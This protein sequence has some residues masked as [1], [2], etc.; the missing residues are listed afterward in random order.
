MWHL[1]TRLGTFWVVEKPTTDSKQH[2]YCLGIDDE[3]LGEY[4]DADKA[5]SD[6][7][8]QSTGF[9]RWDCQSRI[10]APADIAHWKEGEPENWA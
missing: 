2:K 7:C 9:L 5:A 3:E 8:S 10:K 4:T 1:K 6:V